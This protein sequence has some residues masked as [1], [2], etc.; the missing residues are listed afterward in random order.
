MKSNYSQK[1]PTQF[2]KFHVEQVLLHHQNGPNSL[3]ILN[4]VINNYY[5]NNYCTL[6]Q[7]VELQEGI[8]CKKNLDCFVCQMKSPYNNCEITTSESTNL[9]TWWKWPNMPSILIKFDQIKIIL[10]TSNI[11]LICLYK[12]EGSSSVFWPLSLKIKLMLRVTKQ[13][14]QH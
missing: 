8:A 12:R 7:I 13:T 6:N 9:H 14:A 2:C 11:I 1:T 3:N 10:P 4:N 5:K